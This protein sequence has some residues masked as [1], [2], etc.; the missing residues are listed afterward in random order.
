[1]EYYI[2]EQEAYPGGSP[3]NASRVCAE[4]MK[5]VKI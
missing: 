5:K 1:M 2:G 4:Y 3:L